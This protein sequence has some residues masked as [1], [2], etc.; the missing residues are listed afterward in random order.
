M[1]SCLQHPKTSPRDTVEA[2]VEGLRLL[3]QSILQNPKVRSDRGLRGD[4]DYLLSQIDAAAEINM[5]MAAD[6]DPSDSRLFRLRVNGQSNFLVK[7]ES[8]EAAAEHFEEEL[9]ERGVVAGTFALE[10]MRLPPEDAIS[11][12]VLA[13]G[14]LESKS[15]E[16]ILDPEAIPTLA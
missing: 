11:D 16:L 3:A 15:F 6:A 14:I 7:A 5:A 13:S 9:R 12:G 10:I 4:L 2:Q 1:R 8:F